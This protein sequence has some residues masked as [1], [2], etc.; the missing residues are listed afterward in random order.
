MHTQSQAGLKGFFICEDIHKDFCKKDQ[1]F[2]NQVDVCLVLVFPTE[3]RVLQRVSLEV[4]LAGACPSWR[5]QHRGLA[6]VGPYKGTRGGL[7]EMAKHSLWAVC[8][9]CKLKCSRKVCSIAPIHDDQHALEVLLSLPFWQP[10][11]RRNLI[12]SIRRVGERC[13]TGPLSGYVLL[14]CTTKASQ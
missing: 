1:T 11:K 7:L 9:A 14:R 10:H 6:W 3:E 2:L 8:C 12:V 4:C 13:L 5:A